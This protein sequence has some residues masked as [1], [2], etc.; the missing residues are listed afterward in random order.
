MDKQA[1][2]PERFVTITQVGYHPPGM[3]IDAITTSLTGSGDPEG[4][5]MHVYFGVPDGDGFWL[6]VRSR[7]GILVGMVRSW[8]DAEKFLGIKPGGYVQVDHKFWPT[9]EWLEQIAAGLE[10]LAKQPKGGRA[11]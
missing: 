2:K 1:K 7:N 5:D 9:P 11:A 8:A 10:A 3:V 6:R 4:R